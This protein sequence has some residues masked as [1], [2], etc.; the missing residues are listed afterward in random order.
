MTTTDESPISVAN[1]FKWLTIMMLFV[2]CG[3][4]FINIRSQQ[5]AKGK[6]I[7]RLKREQVSLKIA[8]Q[9]VEANIKLALAPGAL[10]E[11]LGIMES[12]LGPVSVEQTEELTPQ[13]TVAR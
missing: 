8:M 3:C 9:N 2:V 6:E 11:R 10:E 4:L 7:Q 5:V 12:S 1:L 13:M